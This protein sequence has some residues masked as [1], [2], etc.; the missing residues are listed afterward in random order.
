MAGLFGELGHRF[1]SGLAISLE[2]RSHVHTI[3]IRVEF[4]HVGLGRR[5]R[6]CSH[7]G[8]PCCRL[9]W[10]EQKNVAVENNGGC[11]LPL[12]SIDFPYVGT[13]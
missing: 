11:N 8:V 1:V 2:Q 5:L 7:E 13:M 12:L 10:F 4:G 6:L 3:W 9:L